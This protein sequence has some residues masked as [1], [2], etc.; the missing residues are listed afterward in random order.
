MKF[1]ESLK[2][3]DKIIEGLENPDVSLEDSMEFYKKGTELISSC[4]KELA[5]AEMLVTVE[6]E[7]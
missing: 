2:M 5:K 3:L 7:N 1:E 4:R 6:E